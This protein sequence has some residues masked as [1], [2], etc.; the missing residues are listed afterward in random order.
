MTRGRL[1]WRFRV[2]IVPIDTVATEAADRFDYRMREP[3]V[4]VSGDEGVVEGTPYRLDCQFETEGDSFEALRTMGSGDSPS[5]GVKVVFHFQALE[6]LGYVDANGRATIRKGDRL[7][8]VYDIDDILVQSFTDEPVVVT[9]VQPRSF[10]LSSLRRNLLLVSFD[11][12]D[13]STLDVS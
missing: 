9:E 2:E 7:A 8:G 6:D 1:I 5:G 11:R 13:L 4:L 12:R 10:G 3:K